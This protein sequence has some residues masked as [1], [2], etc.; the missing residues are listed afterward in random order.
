M[1]Q[2][3]HPWTRTTV[4]L[5]T[6]SFATSVFFRAPSSIGRHRPA[7]QNQSSPGLVNLQ[8]DFGGFAPMNSNK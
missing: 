6:L 8:F 3:D 4:S 2:P 7:K 5:A 1:P